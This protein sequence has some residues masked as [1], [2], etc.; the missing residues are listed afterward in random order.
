MAFSQTAQ[1]PTILVHTTQDLYAAYNVRGNSNEQGQFLYIEPGLLHWGPDRVNAIAFEP[2]SQPATAY[3]N[4]QSK[5]GTKGTFCDVDGK[6]VEIF[7]GRRAGV[8]Y[9]GTYNCYHAR[10][11]FPEGVRIP[12][13]SVPSRDRIALCPT[14]ELIVDCMVLE[15]KGYNHDLYDK[16]IT[17]IA[18]TGAATSMKRKAKRKG[19]KRSR[20]KV[21]RE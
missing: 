1:S 9:A 11:W 3:D 7:F 12:S 19:G 8:S 15:W 5:H 4:D 10:D 6:T 18:G 13:D 16:L 17:A 14:G 2:F 20:K 21:K